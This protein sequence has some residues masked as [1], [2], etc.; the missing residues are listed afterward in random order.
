PAGEKAAAGV[1]ERTAG[2]AERA[3]AT[4]TTALRS[5]AGPA[6]RILW[7]LNPRPLVEALSERVQDLRRKRAATRA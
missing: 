4:V 6:R 1:D 2:R 7:T 5:E 3:A